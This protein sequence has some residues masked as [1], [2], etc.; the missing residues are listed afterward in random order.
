MPLYLPYLLAFLHLFSVFLQFY[1][2]NFVLLKFICLNYHFNLICYFHFLTL[3]I[4]LAHFTLFP[5]P[6]RLNY[7]CFLIEIDMI[8]L[9]LNLCFKHHLNHNFIHAKYYRTKCFLHRL[10]A[11]NF[12]HHHHHPHLPPHH[13]VSLNLINYWH[14]INYQKFN[15]H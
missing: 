4:I 15:D 8:N 10:N 14:P 9:N 6:L 1:H 13:H 2:F 11:H 5:E 12:H 3:I 7:C